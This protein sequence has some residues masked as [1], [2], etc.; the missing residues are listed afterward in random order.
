MTKM[1]KINEL[2]NFYK[3]TNNDS[4]DHWPFIAEARENFYNGEK[5]IIV[6]IL[7]RGINLGELQDCDTELVAHM[8]IISLRSQEYEWAIKEHNITLEDYINLMIDV[9]IHGISKRVEALNE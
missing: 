8:M 9:M 2:I 1:A 5:K 6:D 4:N 7:T 3:V